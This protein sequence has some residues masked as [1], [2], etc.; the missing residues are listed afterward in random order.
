M[1]AYIK[2][3][4][5]GVL[6]FN[7]TSLYSANNTNAKHSE[8]RNISS[9]TTIIQ[10]G[11]DIQAALNSSLNYS[12]SLM[13]GTSTENIYTI[14]ET[15]VVPA[16]KELTIPCGAVLKYAGNTT[17]M[18]LNHY[19]TLNGDGKLENSNAR[20][21]TIT[22]KTAIKIIGSFVTVDFGIIWGFE[23]GIDMSGNYF[24]NY[25]NIKIRYFRDVLAG[26][27]IKPTGIYT[28]S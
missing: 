26:I 7:L 17:A 11:E 10:V 5:L 4:L 6:L 16:N 1:N 25:N 8:K 15:L 9:P 27:I 19:S 20:W 23:K 24:M 12:V 13:P 28:A 3:I 14:Y 18:M 22:Q 21:D 2:I